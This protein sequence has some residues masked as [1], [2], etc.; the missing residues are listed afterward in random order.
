LVRELSW[1]HDDCGYRKAF[2][3]KRRK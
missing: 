1:L 2:G 3:L